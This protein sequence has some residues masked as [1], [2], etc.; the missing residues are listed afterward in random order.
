MQHVTRRKTYESRI[1][2]CCGKYKN[3]GQFAHPPQVFEILE[4]GLKF[5]CFKELVSCLGQGLQAFI[6]DFYS[7]ISFISKDVVHFF[8]RMI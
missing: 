5:S 7:Q 6:G 3:A 2:V 4:S 1:S 8:A